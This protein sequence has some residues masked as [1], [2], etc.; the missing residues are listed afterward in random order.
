LRAGVR[1]VVYLIHTGLPSS[2]L[3]LLSSIVE[4]HSIIPTAEQLAA[5]PRDAH[6]PPEAAVPLLLADLLPR[7]LER[8]LFLDADLL[9]LDDLVTLWETPLAGHVLAA[10]RDSAVPLC[11]SPRA[12]KDWG[13]L[14]I[15]ADAPY[16]NGGV[17]LIHLERWRQRH[18][19]ARARHYLESAR[20][21]VDFLHQEALNAAM[22]NDWKSLDPRWNLIASHAGRSH[23]PSASPAWR[24]P[25]I[26]HFAGRMKPWRGPIAGPFHAPYRQMLQRVAPQLAPPAPSFPDRLAS[27]Y[28][29]YFRAAFFP[30]ENYLWQ[31]RI[32]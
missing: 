23:D 1:P 4:V 8:V 11:S 6:F 7:E 13:E 2:S 17:L 25:G 16:F 15:H 5:A 3:T 26:V 18:I 27:V 29:R 12:V 30:L 9:V 19:T 20:E 31:Q 21:P 24:Q 10:V 14:G 32:L 28:D 22:W